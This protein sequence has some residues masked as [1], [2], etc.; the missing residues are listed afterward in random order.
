MCG[1]TV[2]T[3]I[4][5]WAVKRAKVS[6]QDL[7]HKFGNWN[8]WLSGE[9][10]PSVSDLKKLA[11]LTR[12]PVPLYFVSQIPETSLPVKDFRTALSEDLTDPS[13]DLLETIH[14]CL[15]HQEWYH[16]YAAE[17]NLPRLKFVGSLSGRETPEKAAEVIRKDLNLCEDKWRKYENYE[18]ALRGLAS[19]AE[20]AGLLIMVSPAA[21]SNNKR[22]L[23]PEEF[24]GLAL[25]DHYAPLIFLNSA[26]S[27]AAQMFTMGHELAQIWLGNS[28]ISNPEIRKEGDPKTP[29]L[30]CNAAAAELLM[31]LSK[32]PEVYKSKE[33]RIIDILSLAKNFKIS[34]YI[35][36][37]RFYDAN[38]ISKDDMHSF[39]GQL[40]AILSNAKPE[41]SS[42]KKFGSFYPLIGR[43]SLKFTKA[44]VES[45]LAGKTLH[46]DAF[47]L[48]G[49]RGLSAFKKLTDILAAN[50]E[51][52]A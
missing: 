10:Q 25:S 8:S 28:G 9:L 35:S 41:S 30:W 22:K 1:L 24:K 7:N 12:I 5:R 44:L 47:K 29:E 33:C 27:Q 16:E 49:I 42:R 40:T 38:Y 31:P 20:D 4:L 52:L 32:I 17:K 45:T 23:N 39:Y 18:A 21:G 46:R 15:L 14:S 26:D 50:N 11:H 37:R 6:E 48:L 36:L 3:D 43:S 2:N 19:R 51:I 34:P 13:L